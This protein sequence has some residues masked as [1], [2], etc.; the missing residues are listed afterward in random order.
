[1]LKERIGF[2]GSGNMA[3][4]L[5]GGLIADGIP[6]E[7]ITVA[8]PSSDRRATLRAHFAINVVETGV[9]LLEST[10]IIILAV[11]PQVIQEVCHSIGEKL[12]KN[13]PLFISIAAGIHVDDIDRWLGGEQAIVRTM[14]NTPAMIRTG[15]TGLYANARVSKEQRELSESILRAVG[16]TIW[17]ETEDELDIVTAL[18]GSGPAYFFLIIELMQQSAQRLGL[19]EESSKLL[20]LQTAFGATKM[21]LESSD[22]C[23]TLRQKVTSPG[24]TTER[25]ISIMLD[26]KIDQTIDKALTG[27]RDRARELADL[28]GK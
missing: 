2:I 9:A 8:E 25:A 11:K 28:L 17:V 13:S 22:D 15:A 3:S 6:P 4:S 23:A 7:Q 18:S 20:A 21:A 16:V 5:I 27:A 26:E 1:M 12:N 19:S 10:E 24:G 14:P